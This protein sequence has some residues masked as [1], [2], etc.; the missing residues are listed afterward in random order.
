MN[1]DV[2]RDLILK[3]R[4]FEYSSV[5]HFDF[6]QISANI[7]IA[8]IIIIKVI[9]MK[10]CE[11]EFLSL[12]EVKLAFYNLGNIF[13]RV[14]NL[15]RGTLCQMCSWSLSELKMHTRS[16][17]MVLPPHTHDQY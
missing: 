12:S 16:T 7:I 14:W 5:I 13:R 2:D 4:F 1:F 17:F 11:C 3:L 15:E 9:I 6:P 8:K 10:I